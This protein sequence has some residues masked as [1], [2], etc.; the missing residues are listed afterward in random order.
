[1]EEERLRMGVATER[2]GNGG[3][4][5]RVDEAPVRRILL[6]WSYKRN[7]V[8]ASP[9]AGGGGGRKGREKAGTEGESRISDNSRWL[10]PADLPI[11]P[12]LS[13]TILL[14]PKPRQQHNQKLIRLL[15]QNLS[16]I[17]SQQQR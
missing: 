12:R 2:S 10:L 8:S 16:S 3:R 15:D 7:F 5:W 1:M 13:G 4:G 11:F 14:N 6:G 17:K 9:S